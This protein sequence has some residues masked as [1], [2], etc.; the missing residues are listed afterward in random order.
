MRPPQEQNF[1]TIWSHDPI[2]KLVRR[3]LETGRLPHALMLHGPD[4]VGKRTL[5]FAIAKL[6][7]S[8]GRPVAD[9][10]L[11]ASGGARFL[12][13]VGEPDRD[14]D[15][16]LFG[17]MDDLFG[18]QEDLFGAAEETESAPSEK[19]AP[20]PAPSP[21]KVSPSAPVPRKPAPEPVSDVPSVPQPVALDPRVDRLVSR[22]YP[23]EYEGDAVVVKGH[24][25]LTIIEPI[26][27][28]KSIKVEQVRTLQDVGWMRPIEGDK[29]VIVI[30][31]A[32]T[33]TASAAN[34]LLKLLEEPPSFLALILVT[35]HYH[36]VLETIRSRCASL[37]CHPV[38][39]EE[40]KRLLVQEEGFEPGLAAVASALSGG[41]VARALEVASKKLL[42]R[43]RK[44]FDARLDVDREG[45]PA[46]P[47]AAHTI[48]AE[49]DDI[50][51][52][53][54]LLMS[55]ARDRAVRRLTPRANQLLVHG[56]M[57]SLL[58]ESEAD[59]VALWEESERLLEFLA[60]NDHP[61]VPAPEAGLELALWPE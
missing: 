34:S 31:G 54:A 11:E 28:S 29:R 33:I 47:R 45:L 2:K 38:P 21:E 20:A 27:T 4:G 42:D 19:T 12:W 25:D 1:E 35:N 9:S 61:A 36:R 44:V 32:D 23:I 52:A 49:T 41:S 13:R 48:L 14:P 55:L 5:A 46:L 56:D 37:A 40:L 16:H 30:F 60:L 50:E 24:V 22:S 10:R 17:G 58:D 43:R 7:L 15:D 53:V 39:R 3:M 6:I 18:E 57:E 59:P 26:A 8:A 51:N